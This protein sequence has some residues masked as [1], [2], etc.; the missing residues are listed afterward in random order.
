MRSLIVLLC[1]LLPAIALADTHEVKMLNRNE[2]GAMVY[3]PPYL[4]IAAG[5]TVRF[6]ATK[7][8]HNAA[9]ID[10]MLPNGAEPFKGKI[11]KE[12]EIVL[13]AEGIYGVKCSP[14]YAMGMVMII[15][16][17]KEPAKAEDVPQSIPE[18]ARARLLTYIERHSNH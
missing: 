10:E 12:I 1:L 9:S 2:N 15:Q 18:R 11:D 14:H 17:G 3:D 16:V 8:G 5:D 4:K 7:P 13:D 6:I